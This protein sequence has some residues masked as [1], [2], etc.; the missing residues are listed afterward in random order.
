MEEL[1]AFGFLVLVIITLLFLWVFISNSFNR[2]QDIDD[3]YKLNY[4]EMKREK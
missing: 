2:I 4:K 1:I 3:M